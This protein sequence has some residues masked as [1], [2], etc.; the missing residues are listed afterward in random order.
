[1]K[2]KDYC[3]CGESITEHI[4]YYGEVSGCFKDGCPCKK[5]VSEAAEAAF[6]INLKELE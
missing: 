5:F 2:R 6:N 1:M 3:T 4:D